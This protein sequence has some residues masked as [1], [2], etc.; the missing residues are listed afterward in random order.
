M[1]P[2][3]AQSLTHGIPE[4]IFLNR[5]ILKKKSADDKKACKLPSV[6]T[7]KIGILQS[8]LCEEIEELR[9][10]E[11]SLRDQLEMSNQSQ[12]QYKETIAGLETR[13]TQLLAGR[14]SEVDGVVS[15]LK[16][17]EQVGHGAVLKNESHEP[18]GLGRIPDLTS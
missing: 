9:C 16:Q 15:Q 17:A 7:V 8:S 1:D 5:Y 13:L 4:I 11:T 14:S 3:W 6:Q 2:D 18:G 12:K 10:N